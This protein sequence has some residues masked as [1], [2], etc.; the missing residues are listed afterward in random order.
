MAQGGNPRRVSLVFP[1]LLMTIGGLFLYSNGHPSF[2]PW[3]FMWRYWP[4]ILIFVGLGKILDNVRRSKD[5]SA[6][7]DFPTGS[8]IGILL[9]VLLLMVVLWRGRAFSRDHNFSSQMQHDARIVD[10]Q[11]AQSVAATVNM[12]AGELTVSGGTSHLLDAAFD[13]FDQSRAPSVDYNVSGGRGDLEISNTHSDVRVVA[14]G[15]NTRWNLH[16]GNAA[17]LNLDI[18]MG[19]GEGHLRLRDLPLTNLSLKIGAGRAEVDL[20]G[21]RK[22]DLDAELQG[23]VGEAIIHLPKNIGVIVNASGGIGSIDASDFKHEDGEYTNAAYGK[24][25]ATIH[26]HVTGG[27]GHIRLIQ[28]P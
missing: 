9:F 20:T 17:P 11:G 21:D 5:P 19:A 12:T 7:K 2:S 8:T 26:L 15:S 3:P 4:L 22:K 14:P 18:S 16:F 1:I 13:Y 25:P 24:S 27:I 10:L 28:E 6:T 23:G